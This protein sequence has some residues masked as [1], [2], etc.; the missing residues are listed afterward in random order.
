MPPQLYGLP[1][2][3]RLRVAAQ[4]VQ[5]RFQRTLFETAGETK[6]TQVETAGE[7]KRTQVETQH[8]LGETDARSWVAPSPSI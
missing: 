8:A 1:S 5:V 2:G 4:N 3:A 7:T 6:R